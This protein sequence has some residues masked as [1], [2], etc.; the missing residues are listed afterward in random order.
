M[1][2][3]NIAT[4]ENTVTYRYSSKSDRF[5]DVADAPFIIDSGESI[6]EI[7][8]DAHLDAQEIDAL[9]DEHLFNNAA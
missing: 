2:I 8:I 3:I 1:N 7:T 5:I 6:T 4:T 9:F